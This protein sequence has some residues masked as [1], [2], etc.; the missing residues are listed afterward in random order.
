MFAAMSLALNAQSFK[1]WV[2]AAENAMVSQ[3]YYSAL[4][5]YTEALEFD[6]T[7]TDLK[8]NTAEA[9]RLFN[10]YALAEEKY[11][12]VIDQD[13]D[14][15]YPLASFWLADMKQKL[16]KYEESKELFDFYLSENDGDDEYYTSKAMKESKACAWAIDLLANPDENIHITHLDENINTAYS[17]FG[18][19]KKDDKIYFSSLKFDQKDSPYNPDRLISKI[20]RAEEFDLAEVLDA[21]VNHEILHTA[22]NAFT[23]DQKQMYFTICHFITTND[24][25]CDLYHRSVN[26]D[27]TFGEAVKLPD[28]INSTAFTSTQPNVGLSPNGEKEV[29][30]FVS[31]RPGGEGKNDIWYTEI[32]PDGN[33]GEPVNLENI[34]T[35][36]DDITP[37]YHRPTSKLYFSSEGYQG[38]GGFDIYMAEKNKR[39]EYVVDMLPV[40]LN[41]SY[42]D[43]YYTIN[44][45]LTEAY[46]SSNRF[47][48]FFLENAQEACCYD[49]YKAEIDAAKINLTVLTFDNNENVLLDAKVR[50]IDLRTGKEFVLDPMAPNQH[51]IELEANREYQIISEK[52]NYESD[53]MNFSTHQLYNEKEITK[54][55]FLKT[56]FV[57]LEVLSFD[58]KSGDAL[59]GTTVSLYDAETN[60]L[61]QTLGPNSISN[62]FV[63]LVQPGRKYKVVGTKTDYTSASEFVSTVDKS[64][65]IIQKL[66]L[67]K[68]T[69][70]I[71]LP[72]VMYY[73]NDYPNPRSRSKTTNRTYTDTYFPYMDKKD[74]F[75]KEYGKPLRGEDKNIADSDIENFF[76]GDVRSGFNNM[77]RFFTALE[78]ELMKGEKI[79]IEIKGFAS[80]RASSQYNLALGER[81]IKAL[82]NEMHKYNKGALLNFLYNEQLII[83]DVSYG[84]TQAPSTVSDDL[85]DRRNSVY[86]VAASK[87]RRV[88][89]VGVNYLNIN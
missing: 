34:N 71:Y 1:A 78:K 19:Y 39:D 75:K 79:E 77:K 30:Y 37:F 83:R 21:D 15:E 11:Q 87:E 76:E 65:K 7:R 66:F 70:D 42:H 55:V 74:A 63:F 2:A 46:F 26:N 28:N 54:K 10:A 17:E 81:R 20:L 44:D 27:G 60:E 61:I 58:R 68:Q 85:R 35:A 59:N 14:G 73:D 4:V 84:E 16:G 69:L 72:L 18:A 9:A 8:Y 45:T 36:E 50:I 31:D 47:G 6:E 12:Q 13:G 25:R 5:Y 89:V 49:I 32:G 82:V 33:Y 43:I 88:E 67:L 64:G 40:P 57:E 56:K 38:L 3:D 24:I 53:T 48:S 51:T 62:S 86:S 23:E 22:H 80:P 52:T 29:L 41:S